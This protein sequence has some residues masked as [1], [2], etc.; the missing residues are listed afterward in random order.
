MKK[1]VFAAIALSSLTLAAC[2]GT[3][4][5]NSEVANVEQTDDLNTT[6]TLDA[7]NY[8]DA[9][10]NASD[11]NTIGP[12]DNAADLNAATPLENGVANAL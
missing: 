2:G 4:T 6:D 10:L 12:V 5:G 11:L 9:S 8:G 1:T 3:A 7:G